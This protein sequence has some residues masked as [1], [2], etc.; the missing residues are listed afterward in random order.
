MNSENL[1]AKP[2]PEIQ[3]GNATLAGPIS[4]WAARHPVLIIWAASALALTVNCFPVIFLGRSFVAPTDGIPLVYSWGMPLPEMKPTRY[5]SVHGSDIA[6]MMI[7]EVPAGFVESRSVW[8]HGELP[9]WDR[10]GHCGYTMI[11]QA[12]FMLEDPLQWIVIIG[13]GSAPAWDIKFL[14]AK[15]LFCVGFGLLILRLTRSKPLAAIYAALAAY[16]GAFF[17]INAHPSFFV[18][19]YSPWVLLSALALLDLRSGASWRAGLGWL[20]ANV[21]CF[22]GGDAEAAVTLIGGLNLAAFIFA[23]TSCRAMGDVA[24]VAGRMAVGTA[25][26]LGL[27]APVWMT[28]W[29]ALPCS[30]TAHQQVF[31]GLLPF[32]DSARAANVGNV[33]LQ[34]ILAGLVPFADLMGAFEDVFYRRALPGPQYAPP[35]P[36]TSLLVMAGSIFAALR[37]RELKK[38]RFFWINSAAIFLWGGL[39]FG[40]IPA[41]V[42]RHIPLFNRVGH[43]YTDFSYLL[44]IHLTIQSAYGFARLAAARD[45]RRVAMDFAW[46]GLIAAAMLGIY[47]VSLKHG[48]LPW[49]YLLC[50]GAGAAGAPLVFAYL[51]SRKGRVSVLGWACVLV[52]GFIAQFRFGIYAFGSDSL[53]MIFGPRVVLNAPS[54]AVDWIKNNSSDPF[55]VMGRSYWDFFGD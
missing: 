16:C 34:H 35:A 5:Y 24:R 31:A 14:A 1:A 12:I 22:N 48:P 25:L 27:T 53:L 36:G 47:C 38:E 45:F 15:L 21:A 43:A 50:V 44:V 37:W 52:L 7:G 19:C 54:D 13:H 4:S 49:N 6:A 42:I 23:L 40:L 32:T 28:F 55:R 41:A 2:M 20:L 30:Y 9:L 26:F 18:F 17:Y 51:K 10:Y 33:Y 8:E 46:I 11:G 29:R 3:A 39:V